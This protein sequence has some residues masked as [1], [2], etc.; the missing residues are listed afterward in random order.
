M[1]AL[2]VALLALIAVFILPLS[3]TSVREVSLPRRVKLADA[4]F[5]GEVVTL[6]PF[7]HPAERRLY[8]RAVVRVLEVHKGRV[9]SGVALVHRGGTLNGEGEADGFAP[10]FSV[11]EQRLLFVRRQADDTLA[12]TLG[13]SDAPLIQPARGWKQV[14][15]RE[16]NHT[17]LSWLTELRQSTVAGP[18]P[19]ADLSDLAIPDS[20]LSAPRKLDAGPGLTGF[21]SATNLFE[22][23][24]GISAR[25]LA[26]DRGDPI[27]YYIDADA[28]PEGMTQVQ[29]L[30][31]VSD[32]LLAW[33]NASSLRFVFAGMRSFGM[34]AANV[35]ASDG[36]LRIQLHDSY[37]FV[38][39][40]GEVLGR[41]GVRWT[42]AVNGP[43]AG[44]LTGGNVAG[45]DF[46]KAVAGWVV[47]QHNHPFMRNL[48]DFTEVLCHELGHAFGIA[49]SSNDPSES[50]T[51]LRQA[52]MYYTAH[53]DARG[54]LL[55][56]FDTNVIQQ[57][58]PAWNTPPF[59][60]DRLMDVV[61]TPVAQTGLNRIRFTAYDLQSSSLILASSDPTSNSGT[62]S[63]LGQSVQFDPSSFWNGPR[64]DPD[65]G[66]YY[67]RIYLRAADGTNASAYVTVRVVS[68]LPDNYQEG[69]P[70]S[71]RL[72]NFGSAN[73][74]AG[75]N[76]RANQDLDHDGFTNL[77][78][79]HLGSDPANPASN[80]VLTTSPSGLLQWSAKPG[81][82]YEFQSTADF[83][84]WRL[85][86]PLLATVTNASVS[87]SATNDYQFFRVMKVE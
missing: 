14:F 62:F 87:I 40:A 52:I 2:R 57:V 43:A 7:W 26:P 86:Q 79:F 59:C 44:W 30:K 17:A 35:S 80:L 8:T 42:S 48:A 11:G 56:L 73:P 53:G 75:P 64:V 5:R 39:G 45:N 69:I 61:T 20:E 4:V 55:N 19:G 82:L 67:D 63:V 68:L 47:L 32:A 12:V 13:P 72:A 29:A 71:W 38:T 70:D 3:A 54:A 84:S 49:H 65:A 50:N 33:K 10:N 18:L 6:N 21:S 74:A 77:Q 51:Q 78:E 83:Q 25:Y 66:E 46:N 15:R 81:E 28:L 85:W 31:A 16:T 36:A 76:R 24:N 9:P 58:Q 41:G 60:F 22:D 27:P 23:G 1:N 34:A 37:Q